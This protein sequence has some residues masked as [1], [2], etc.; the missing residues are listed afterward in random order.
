MHTGEGYQIIWNV[1]SAKL[2]NKGNLKGNHKTKIPR[3]IAVQGIYV[4]KDYEND[5]IAQGGAFCSPR[6][7]HFRRGGVHF[8]YYVNYSH[9]R[10][11]GC[12][13]VPIP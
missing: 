11:A 12:L 9:I 3:T 6:G 1:I 8:W 2:R 4:A 10:H 13:P 5:R 7:V